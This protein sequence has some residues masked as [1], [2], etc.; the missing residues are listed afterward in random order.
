[1]ISIFENVKNE[2]DKSILIHCRTEKGRGFHHAV[3]AKN[4]LHSIGKFDIETGEEINKKGD[5]TFSDVFGETLCEL[6]RKDEKI[7]VITAAMTEGTGL[8]QFAK[9]FPDRFFDVGIAEQHA[10]TFAAGLTTQGYKP[11]IAIY[12]SFL[13]RAFD[14]VIHDVAIQNLPVRFAIDRVGRALGDGATHDGIYD[15]DLLLSLPNFEVLEPKS[16]KELISAIHKAWKKND[17]PIAF[18]YEKGVAK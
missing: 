16:K 17:A 4:K 12:S 2:V 1:M 18:R 8:T 5:K 9:E 11:F 13:Q 10:V 14:Q 7:V 6:A 15:K 3:K